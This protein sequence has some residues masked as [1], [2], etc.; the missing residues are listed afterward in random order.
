M[1]MHLVNKMGEPDTPDERF[2]DVFAGGAL[3]T[4]YAAAPGHACV[5][6]VERSCAKFDLCTPGAHDLCAL[7]LR[8][9]HSTQ[10]TIDQKHACF[11]QLGTPK[12]QAGI[13]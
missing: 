1:P 13:C 10:A 3:L 9:K 7:G 12:A 8:D 5:L 11:R 2:I 4:R 6:D